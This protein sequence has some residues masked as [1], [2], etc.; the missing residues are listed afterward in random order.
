MVGCFCMP[1]IGQAVGGELYL[2]ALTG[3]A[4]EQTSIQLEMSVW[5]RKGGDETIFRDTC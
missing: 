1:Y 4:D 2:M 5:L 3:G